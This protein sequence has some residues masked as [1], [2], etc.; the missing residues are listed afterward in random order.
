VSKDDR[1]E[2][3]DGPGRTVP[4]GQA[5]DPNAETELA[6]PVE[7][8]PK[9]GP[10]RFV[11]ADPSAA[12]V[13]RPDDVPTKITE[14]PA[15][16]AAG[17]ALPGDPVGVGSDLETISSESDAPSSLNDSG[18]SHS[19][20]DAAPSRPLD[21]D[22]MTGQRLLNRY[23][24]HEKLGA[25]GFGSVYHA[26]DELKKSGGE[27]GNI[28]IKII[29]TRKIGDILGALVQEVSRSHQ[30]SHPNI[31][32][33]YDIHSDQGLAFITME[34]L[35]GQ[36]L[37][38]RLIAAMAQTVDHKSVL[39]VGEVDEI[40]RSACDALIHCH[41][42]DIVHSDIK[43]A[44]IFIN[45]QGTA[46]L[47]DLGI[48]QLKGH[49]ANISGFSALYSSPE[50]MVGDSADPRD[51][52]FALGCV[53]YECLTGDRPFGGLTSKAARTSAKPIDTSIL[54]RRYRKAL[55]GVL[56][57]SRADRTPTASKL[58]RQINPAI[59]KRNLAIAVATLL[60]A[61]AFIATNL[62]GQMKGENAIAVSDENKAV[63]EAAYERAMAIASTQ[64]TES[65]SALVEAI[66]ANP[67]Y[68]PAAQE[69]AQ[70]VREAKSNQPQS[71]SSAWADYGAAIEASPQ[72]ES[73]LEVGKE[74]I[75]QILS[76]DFSGL[77]RSRLLS[78]Y[79]APLC[80]LG[81]TDYRRTELE[82]LRTE[83]SI[84]C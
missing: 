69:L 2:R 68:E 60:A 29:D 9:S 39:P 16:D 17:R 19:A 23:L 70:R 7:E 54:P 12:T 64:P 40:A 13:L 79:L 73:L 8:D 53:L 47:L 49:R 67:Y 24:I 18:A 1:T 4:L 48:S 35:E 15:A 59:P 34:L 21:V 50:Q 61:V 80:I 3:E 37:A 31:V 46:K 36:T 72:S 26:T 30:V 71:Y 57:L 10:H 77:P 20:T 44:N 66:R 6:A 56:A 27:A 78:E 51:D 32:R 81:H 43:P 14:T 5:S 22:D 38:D 74:R 83:L 11:P 84:R 62:A 63:A 55:K 75:D 25:G 65:R 76:T 58:W 33:V 41:E 28:A 52:L 42:R 82:R 45:S